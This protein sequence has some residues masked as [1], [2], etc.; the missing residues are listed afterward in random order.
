MTLVEKPDPRKKLFFAVALDVFC[1]LG[2]VAAFLTSG[3]ILWLLL[4]VLLG[5]G[6]SAPLVISAMR[7]LR[8]QNNASG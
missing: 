4:S 8:E 3:S 7:E 1:V 5:A 6:V 2:G